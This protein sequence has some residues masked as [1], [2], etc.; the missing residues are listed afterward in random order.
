MDL[1]RTPGQIESICLDSGFFRW[2]IKDFEDVGKY[3][4]VP[5]EDVSRYQ[6]AKSSK[7]IANNEMKQAEILIPDRLPKAQMLDIICY[8][9]GA[10]TRALSILSEFGIKKGVNVNQ[11]WYFMN[12]QQVGPKEG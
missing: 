7:L 11:G 8:S 2:R 4:D 10:K 3:W 5:I 12:S 9:E 1:R 6:F